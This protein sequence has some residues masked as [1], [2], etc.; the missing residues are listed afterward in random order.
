MSR[1]RT[2]RL[3]TRRLNTRARTARGPARTLWSERLLWPERLL[4]RDRPVARFGFYGAAGLAKRG[5]RAGQGV[6]AGFAQRQLDLSIAFV[7]HALGLVFG[8]QGG[9][10]IIGFHLA[11]EFHIDDAAVPFAVADLPGQ[12][13]RRGDARH[14]VD[15]HLFQGLYLAGGFIRLQARQRRPGFVIDIDGKTAGQQAKRC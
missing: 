1:A 10:G 14:F 6:R 13:A 4:W 11:A 12:G 15:R 2:R 9:V 8:A 7:G 5:N 3:K